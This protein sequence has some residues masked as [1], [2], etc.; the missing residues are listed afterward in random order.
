MNIKKT[1]RA[2]WMLGA[3]IQEKRVRRAIVIGSREHWT[4]GYYPQKIH[5][6][7]ISYGKSKMKFRPG[8]LLRNERTKGLWI[9]TEVLS[10]NFQEVM[11]T[12]RKVTFKLQM[13]ATCVQPGS[14]Q[15]NHPGSVDTWFF[16]EAT[17]EDKNHLWT[18]INEV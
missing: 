13:S 17:G 10:R 12:G 16:K 7:W 4:H 14:S 11:M 1:G 3:Y 2:L 8:N 18:V 15:I 5:T 9:V 6:L